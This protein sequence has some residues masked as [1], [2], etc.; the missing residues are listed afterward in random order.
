MKLALVA[1][2][3]SACATTE[4][5]HTVSDVQTQ[6]VRVPVPVPCFEPKDLPERP[7][8]VMPK[9]GPDGKVDVE[10]GTAG[11]LS[12]VRKLRDPGEYLDQVDALFKRCLKGP[13]P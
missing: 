11:A 5:Q 8:S 10:Q 3:L 4:S 13:A 1:I 2:L 6:I 7:P 9:P 12:D